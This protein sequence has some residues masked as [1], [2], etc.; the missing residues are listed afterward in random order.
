MSIFD[1]AFDALCSEALRLYDE[2]FLLYDADPKSE[3]AS[4]AFDAAYKAQMLVEIA[5]SAYRAHLHSLA[6]RYS[7]Q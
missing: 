7:R 1:P 5:R 4:R 2:A 6:S 3:A